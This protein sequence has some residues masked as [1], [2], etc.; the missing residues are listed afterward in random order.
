MYAAYPSAD[1]PATWFVLGGNW[2][3]LLAL[4]R[5][6]VWLA[7]ARGRV[8]RHRVLVSCE[9]VVLVRGLGHRACSLLRGDSGR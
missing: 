3:L 6:N 5:R 2:L 7:L 1:V 4:Q 8:A 9:S